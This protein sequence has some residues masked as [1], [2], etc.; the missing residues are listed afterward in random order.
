MKSVNFHRDEIKAIG[1]TYVLR[2]INLS[3]SFVLSKIIVFATLATYV[4]T[5]N[6]L[7]AEKVFVAMSLFQNVRQSMTVNF[8]LG[9][10]Y[11]AETIVVIKRIEVI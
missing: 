6:S 4:L 1:G 2:A 10:A 7:S 5:G 9:I 3:L 8:P 11:L